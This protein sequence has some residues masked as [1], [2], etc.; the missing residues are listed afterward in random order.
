MA[1]D[2]FN[3]Q[4]ALKEHPESDIAKH[5]AEIH[6]IDREAYLKD[7][8]SDKDFIQEFDKRPIP[9]KVEEWNGIPVSAPEETPPSVG[10]VAG[11][12]LGG[13]G[14]LGKFGINSIKNL[15]T[16]T[17]PPAQPGPTNAAAESQILSEH[18]FHPGATSNAV[19]NEEQAAAN[20]LHQ[21]FRNVPGYDVKGNMRIAT[22]SSLNVDEYAAEQA[23]KKLAQDKAKQTLW[24]KAGPVLRDIKSGIPVY[25]KNLFTGISSPLSLAAT[26]YNAVDASNQFNKGNYGRGA[27]A[28]L[29]AAGALASELPP[30]AYI[31]EDIVKY[32]GLGISMLAPYLNRKIDEYY[33]K[34]PEHKRDGG[35]IHLYGE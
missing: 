6:D 33:E 8:K 16:P 32:G 5:L 11:S 29:G 22:P 7:G 2:Y 19:F 15:F 4:E 18:G 23:A 31:P 20:K 26:G 30:S 17:A 34:H 13:S 27:L 9:K 14:A 10:A 35:L 12:V 24:Q 21:G 1:E 25:A 28:T 3:T